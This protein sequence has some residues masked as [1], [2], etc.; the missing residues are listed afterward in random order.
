MGNVKPYAILLKA[1]KIGEKNF[2][3]LLVIRQVRKSFLPPTFFTV[4]YL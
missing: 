2:G 3:E 1:V 4:L